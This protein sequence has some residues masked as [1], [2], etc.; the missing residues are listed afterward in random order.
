MEM[1]RPRIEPNYCPMKRHHR[2]A[3]F[4][5]F[6]DFERQGGGV[7]HDPCQS[8]LKIPSSRSKSQERFCCAC[9]RRYGLVSQSNSRHPSRF[10]L[11]VQIGAQALNSA[12]RPNLRQRFLRH[13]WWKSTPYIQGPSECGGAGAA[14][15]GIAIG[16]FHSLALLDIA[17]FIHL[18][19]LR[20]VCCS[21]CERS[22]SASALS[23]SL[24]F[25]LACAVRGFLFFLILFGCLHP[26]DRQ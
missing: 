22:G 17:V 14:Q 12:A 5:I 13:G 15:R 2:V 6:L 10:Q 11:L 24:T 25:A 19:C 18:L 26:V 20:S 8:A 23:S 16:Q 4:G 3:E 9:R 21:S 7:G 1:G